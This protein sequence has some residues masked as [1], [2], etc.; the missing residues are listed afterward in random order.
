[1]ATFDKQLKAV[2]EAYAHAAEEIREANTKAERDLAN[3][4]VVEAEGDALLGIWAEL[5]RIANAVEPAGEPA[6]DPESK[7][8]DTT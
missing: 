6:A 3:A 5:H 8:G 7:E 1:M 4:N 2:A